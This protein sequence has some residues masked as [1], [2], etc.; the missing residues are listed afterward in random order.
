[1]RLKV[2]ASSVQRLKEKLREIFRRGRGRN[3]SRLIEEELTP[4]LRGWLNYFRLAEVKGIFDELD[5]W[6]RRKLRCLIWRQWKRP[7]ARA[8]GLLRH[9]LQP[10]RAWESATNGRGAWWN[11]GLAHERGFSQ[12]LL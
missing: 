7:F 8:K 6:I 10:T 3:L 4:L 11:R 12:I 2:A 1:M 9:G 5:S